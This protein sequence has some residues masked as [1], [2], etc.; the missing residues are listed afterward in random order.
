M[1]TQAKSFT[2]PLR[3]EQVSLNQPSPTLQGID[4]SNQRQRPR[5]KGRN[6]ERPSAYAPNLCQRLPRASHLQPPHG[7]GSPALHSVPLVILRTYPVQTAMEL[8]LLALKIKGLLLG[9]NEGDEHGASEN[10][11][12]ERRSA[13]AAA[14]GLL[15]VRH[16]SKASHLL[17]RC[18]YRIAL[19]GLGKEIEQKGE[20]VVSFI[21][22]LSTC[23]GASSLRPICFWSS[24]LSLT[25]RHSRQLWLSTL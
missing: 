2:L 10:K 7:G 4:R 19:Q 18:G 14:A 20:K 24:P 25:R 8:R 13:L 9:N 23:T 5:R 17:S 12:S 22:M 21:R 15:S 1:G 11:R 3:A 6:R 16:T